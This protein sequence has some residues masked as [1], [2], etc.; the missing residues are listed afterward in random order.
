MQVAGAVP[1]GTPIRF[2]VA[3]F[4]SMENFLK[5]SGMPD[6]KEKSKV[7]RVNPV[8]VISAARFTILYASFEENRPWQKSTVPL[9]SSAGEYRR[10][11]SR[12]P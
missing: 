7:R 11:L 1:E 2:K 5:L 3:D 12:S 10:P 4:R 6:T 9:E 8:P